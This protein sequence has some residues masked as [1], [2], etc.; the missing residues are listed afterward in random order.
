MLRRVDALAAGHRAKTSPTGSALLDDILRRL[1]ADLEH[2][3]HFNGEVRDDFL[4]LLEQTLLFL[5][6]SQ[7]AQRDDYGGRWKYLFAADGEKVPLEQALADDFSLWLKQ[8]PLSGRIACE[9]RSIGGGR[10]DIAIQHGSHR[11]AC[12]VK[13][14]ESDLD[15]AIGGYLSQTAQYQTTGA[16]LGMLIV[17]D[18]T[19]RF[20][21]RSLDATRVE[22]L[23]QSTDIDRKIVIALVAGNRESPSARG[24]L[25]RGDS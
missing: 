25:T 9:V 15:A 1:T 21:D 12:E 3:P 14:E 11:F 8:S 10:V 4:D 6:T 16:A 24:R 19:R 20:Y 23:Q 22:T 13:R 17:L 7:N 18:L 2:H 5:N